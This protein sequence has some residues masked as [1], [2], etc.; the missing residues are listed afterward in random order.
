MGRN[1]KDQWDMEWD[2][3]QHRY[4][5]PP[6]P[7][8]KAQEFI[9]DLTDT[10]AS[11][12]PQKKDRRPLPYN[13]DDDDWGNHH[14]PDRIRRRDTVNWVA[15]G[16]RITMAAATLASGALAWFNRDQIVDATLTLAQGAGEL[17]TG[18]PTQT[19][20]PAKA[21][22]TI[23][24]QSPA[25][26]TPAPPPESNRQPEAVQSSSSFGVNI[27]Y[28]SDGFPISY[29][30]GDQVTAL[31]RT[32]ILQLQDTARAQGLPQLITAI[33]APEKVFFSPPEDVN[34][35]PDRPMVDKLPADT[36]TPEQLSARGITIIQSKDVQLLLRQSA[37]LPGSSLDTFSPGAGNTLLIVLVDGP[38]VS[39]TYMQDPK[40]D[41]VRDIVGELGP[42]VEEYRQ[43]QLQFWQDIER[44]AISQYHQALADNNSDRL[45]ISESQ[46]I[47]AQVHQQDI[48]TTPDARLAAEAGMSEFAGLYD[49]ATRTVFIAVGK[50]EPVPSTKVILYVAADGTIVTANSS[51]SSRGVNNVPNWSGSFPRPSDFKWLGPGAPPTSFPGQMT[52]AQLAAHPF[53]PPGSP[54][55]YPFGAQSPFFSFR[56]E[57][58]H[59]R[60]INAHPTSDRV[61]NYSEWNTDLQAM[62]EVDDAFRLFEASGYQ[63]NGLYWVVFVVDGR[64]F[65]G[66]DPVAQAVVQ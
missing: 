19:P 15:V 56:H 51:S 59:Y 64:I 53:S 3:S 61:Y 30:V 13:Y 32:S 43:Q 65:I 31:D 26:S 47:A 63:N 27:T 58:M 14:Y 25:T 8:E 33:E 7:L 12:F 37:F 46:I 38:T 60:N 11:L 2:P 34:P 48:L 50:L 21:T 9:G 24:L 42:G 20:S 62:G 54:M 44:Q 40:Y 66:Q 16:T 18:P 36:L 10:V 52:D 39:P 57:L 55:A 41:Q 49:P 17:F 45:E 28:G 35:S 5:H 23:D 4:R 6:S 29:Q 1:G 22:P